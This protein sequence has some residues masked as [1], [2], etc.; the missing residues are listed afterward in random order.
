MSEHITAGENMDIIISG[1]FRIP[2]I[3]FYYVYR[4][5]TVLAG[6]TSLLLLQLSAFDL[7]FGLFGFPHFI[8]ALVGGKA[9]WCLI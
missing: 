9:I 1:V 7:L 8:Q 6:N 2:F 4:E 3:L 5:F